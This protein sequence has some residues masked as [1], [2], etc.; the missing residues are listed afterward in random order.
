M[1][2]PDFVGYIDEVD[3]HDGAIL[4]VQHSGATVRVLAR[5]YNGQLCSFEF[6]L[7]QPV[8]SI[9]PENMTLY[10]LTEMAAAA[11]FRRFV[12]ISSDEEGTGMLE[13]VA[14]QIGIRKIADEAAF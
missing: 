1:S 8:E 13:I 2:T 12:F 14:Q 7:V 5:S 4:K 11:P 9:E 10:S 3:I 6:D